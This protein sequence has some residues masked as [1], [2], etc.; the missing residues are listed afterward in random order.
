MAR[1]MIIGG[2]RLEG[3]G[4]VS[5]RGRCRCRSSPPFSLAPVRRG[6]HPPVL[7][8]DGGA[9]RGRVGSATLSMMSQVTARKGGW[10][11]DGCSSNFNTDVTFRSS[12]DDLQKMKNRRQ[13]ATTPEEALWRIFSPVFYLYL[14]P[15]YGDVRNWR[16]VLSEDNLE[17]ESGREIYRRIARIIS[18]PGYIRTSNFPNDV[19]L[20]QLDEGADL[21]TGEIRVAC[22]PEEDDLP[23]DFS[24]CWISGWGETRGY[25]GHENAMNELPVQI[26]ENT[27]CS[28][29]WLRVGIHVLDDQLC[30]GYGDTGACYGDSGGP[31]MC[32][33]NGRFYITGVMSWLI[34]NC[35]A[36]GFPNVFTRVTSYLDWIYEKLDFYEWWRYN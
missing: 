34:N 4:Q 19:A 25:G 2:R 27:D 24:E 36:R 3:R 26:L 23:P 18:H 6:A 13:L 17:V 12:S 28:S 29:M 5:G 7:G 14:R 32:E 22:L 11:H 31:L 16:V 21:T 20:L 30:V 9:L 10:V 33:M 1:P 8:P 15:F 35:S